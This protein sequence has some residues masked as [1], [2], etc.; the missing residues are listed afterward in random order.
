[1]DVEHHV[2]SVDRSMEFNIHLFLFEILRLPAQDLVV[3]LSGRWVLP[4]LFRLK[5][6]Q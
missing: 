4:T 1:M 5:M 3:V 2:T 6:G